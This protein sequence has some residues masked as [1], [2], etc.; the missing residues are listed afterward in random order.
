MT[1]E[2]GF[3]NVRVVENGRPIGMVSTH[4]ENGRPVGMV[5]T[6]HALDPDLKEFVAEM[7]Q[8]EN[9]AGIL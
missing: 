2:R 1:Y 3:R 4:H 5:S 6:H 8:R 9:I 7:D